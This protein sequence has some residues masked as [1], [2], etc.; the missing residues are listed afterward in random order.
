MSYA[1]SGYQLRLCVVVFW[2][3]WAQD[4][5]K[6]MADCDLVCFLGACGHM[7]MKRMWQ[8]VTWC[9]F[10]FFFGACGHR[11]MRRMWQ[12][13]NPSACHHW[14]G[15]A[16]AS[17]TPVGSTSLMPT[18]LVTS[19]T[20]SVSPLHTSCALPAFPVRSSSWLYLDHHLFLICSL[21]HSFL[22][23]CCAVTLHS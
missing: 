8:I 23:K 9:I 7:I 11:I 10:L 16:P 1:Y 13:Q 5:E 17:T 3:L 19:S 20:A 4:H 22:I 18:A 14:P 21:R 2:C 12:R 15:S 6:N